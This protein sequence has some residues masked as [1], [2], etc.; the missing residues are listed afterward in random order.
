MFPSLCSALSTFFSRGLAK[1]WVSNLLV[2]CQTN[3][4]IIIYFAKEISKNIDQCFT[5]G[6]LFVLQRICR[7][8]PRGFKGLKA[9]RK[10]GDDDNAK[11]G[12][13]K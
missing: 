11:A 1:C 4:A 6:F 12:N 3:I 8:Y 13:D 2:V 5:V 10:K 9:Y 7:I